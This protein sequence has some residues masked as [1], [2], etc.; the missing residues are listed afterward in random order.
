[1]NRDDLQQAIIEHPHDDARRL[2]FADWLEQHGDPERAEFIRVQIE[3]AK[4]PSLEKRRPVLEARQSELLAKNED[5]WVRP[6]R[7]RVLSWLF[8][9]GFVGEVTVTAEAYRKH[10]FELV[11]LAPI[12]RIRFDQWEVAIRRSAIEL[13]P[14]SIARENLVLPLGYLNYHDALVI[15]APSPIDEDRLL[16]LNFVLKRSIAVVE[17]ASEQIEEAINRRYGQR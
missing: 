7:D 1:M 4:L 14:E 8:H 13:V 3:L 2:M 12:E 11:H 16:R 17:A 10:T 6:I 5:E 9:R 15:A